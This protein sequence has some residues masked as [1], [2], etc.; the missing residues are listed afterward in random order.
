MNPHEC[1]D[2][3]LSVGL[4]EDQIDTVVDHFLAF[5]EAPHITSISDFNAA[6]TIYAMMDGRL[7]PADLHSPAARY[8]IS[9]GTRIAT[10]E[11]QATTPSFSPRLRSA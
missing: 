4:T 9:L 1:R 5:G 3:F 10:W 2:M 6:T 7:D 8:M 11:D